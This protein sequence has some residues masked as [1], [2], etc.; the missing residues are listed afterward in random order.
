MHNL[1]GVEE[2]LFFV[3]I[4]DYLGEIQQASICNGYIC[5]RPFFNEIRYEKELNYFVYGSYDFICLW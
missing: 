3:G 4:Q 2:I 1:T 5:H